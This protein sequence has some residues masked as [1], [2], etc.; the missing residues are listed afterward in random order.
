MCHYAQNILLAFDNSC[1]A[2]RG[3]NTLSKE[4]YIYFPGSEV[5]GAMPDKEFG[6]YS[7]TPH[8]F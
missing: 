1:R 5:R 6:V 7:R 3:M 2:T 8:T 4:G